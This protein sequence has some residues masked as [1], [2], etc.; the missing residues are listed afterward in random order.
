ML[1]QVDSGPEQEQAAPA[2]AARQHRAARHLSRRHN[3][4]RFLQRVKLAGLKLEWDD[5][6]L[7]LTSLDTAMEKSR[8]SDG[9][10]RALS[11]LTC[12]GRP[13]SRCCDAFKTLP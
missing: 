10:Q 9:S 13:R 8:P 3:A 2:N 7:E 12:A 4:L 5:V 6:S 11:W 1:P